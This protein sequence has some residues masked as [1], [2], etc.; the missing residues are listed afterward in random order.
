MSSD[1]RELVRQLRAGDRRGFDA[2]YRRYGHRVLGFACRLTGCRTEAEDLVQE[3]FGAAYAAAPVFEGRSGLLNWLLG[4][5][6]RRWRDRSR[7]ATLET[8]PPLEDD[9]DLPPAASPGCGLEDQVIRSLT[10]SRA[11]ASLEAPF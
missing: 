3:V 7:R 6:V 1:E 5:T 2:L 10:L 4:I 9:D 11:L 8:V